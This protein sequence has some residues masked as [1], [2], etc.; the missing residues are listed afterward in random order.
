MHAH[1]LLF[2]IVGRQGWTK[3]EARI[4]IIIIVESG[5][6]HSRA[7]YLRGVE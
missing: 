3:L 6:G 4:L 1:T 5:H 2:T 7:T